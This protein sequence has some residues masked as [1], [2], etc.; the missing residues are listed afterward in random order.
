[1][2]FGVYSQH[3]LKYLV[4]LLLQL[5]KLMKMTFPHRN[6]Y[7]NHAFHFS[8]LCQFFYIPKDV[9]KESAA[10]QSAKQHTAL[11]YRAF[12]EPVL[13]D[14]EVS[15]DF[16]DLRPLGFSLSGSPPHITPLFLLIHSSTLQTESNQGYNQYCRK[17]ARHKTFPLLRKNINCFYFRRRT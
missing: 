4:P 17:V 15:T 12:L 6:W 13:G 10:K 2:L 9:P 3:C 7:F 11:T 1:M 5:K 8:G 16:C 14:A